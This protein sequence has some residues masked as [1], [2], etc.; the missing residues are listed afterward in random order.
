M[1]EFSIVQSLFS[2]I[3]KHAKDNRATS[4]IG[5]TLKIG[6]IS[7]IEPHLLQS[8]FDVFKEGTIASKADL[9]IIHQKLKVKCFDCG[10]ELETNELA[11][12]CI[13]CGSINGKITDGQDMLLMSLDMEVE[14][15]KTHSGP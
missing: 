15:E 2:L 11:L 1:H 6:V 9:V 5:V 12:K 14:S 8:A 13:N 3:Q 4:I 7:G 10:M